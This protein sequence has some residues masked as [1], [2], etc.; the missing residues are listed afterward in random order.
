MNANESIFET[1]DNQTFSNAVKAS[2]TDNG[3]FFASENID[4]AATSSFFETD[5]EQKKKPTTQAKSRAV[6]VPSSA[7]KIE[8]TLSYIEAAKASAET[9]QQPTVQQEQREKTKKPKK[10]KQPKTAA[11][12]SKPAVA[13]QAAATPMESMPRRT[14]V[15]TT[16][17][18]TVATTTMEEKRKASAPAHGEVILPQTSKM[19]WSADI[20]LKFGSLDINETQEEEE[21]EQKPSAPTIP[22]AQPAS[23]RPAQQHI[24]QQYMHQQQQMYTHPVEHTSGYGTAAWGEHFEAQQQHSQLQDKNAQDQNAQK[25]GFQAGHYPHYP[26]PNAYYPYP[27]VYGQQYAFPQQ[28]AQATKGF[29]YGAGQRLAG[30]QHQDDKSAPQQ[31]QHQG[32]QFGQPPAPYGF[33]G[34]GYGMYNAQHLHEQSTMGEDLRTSPH[35]AVDEH[36][37][38]LPV[39]YPYNPMA[40]A[41][42]GMYP[43]YG[44]QQHGQQ[45]QQQQP[46][47]A[48]QQSQQ[49]S[50][51]KEQAW[52]S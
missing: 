31:P 11:T 43:G 37:Q 13:E 30:A 40:Y 14:S 20:G 24:P 8:P 29:M 2:S 5:N 7:S 42:Y 23:T 47:N 46:H 26:Y 39:H 38:S 35:Q 4:T 1:N 51:S 6:S 50:R 12:I 52:N 22:Q 19:N 33:G 28:Y 10:S 15:P 17:S 34:Y 21:E 48:Y 3:T 9:E 45:Q 49:S 27:M 32:A 18:A 16:A 44:T 25:Q 41:Y 36:Q